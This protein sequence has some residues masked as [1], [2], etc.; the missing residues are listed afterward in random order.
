MRIALACPYAWDAPGG[1]QVHVRELGERLRRRGH[2]VLGLAPSRRPPAESWMRAVGRPIDV[3]YNR[4]VAPICFSLASAR[5]VRG[6]LRSF[7]PD[8][9]HAHEPLTPSV[10]MFAL[11]AGVAPVVATF[12]SGAERSLLFDVAAPVLRR[13][14]ERIAV[15]VAVSRAAA[16]FAARRVGDG[17]RVVPNGIDLER[18][19]N[20]HPAPL[21]PGRRVL[22]VGRL[23]ERKGFPTAVEAFSLL[24]ARAPDVRLVAVGDGPDA[25]AVEDVP[26]AI[27]QRIVLVGRVP[28]EAL[29]A[30]LAAA[31]LLVAPSVGGESFGVVLLE[32]M[33]AGLPVVASAIPGYDEVVEHGVDGLLVPPRRPQALAAAIERVLSDRRLAEDLGRAGRRRASRYG[34]DEVAERLEAIYAEAAGGPR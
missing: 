28:N 1:V 14:A 15:R 21:P 7:A 27:R 6:E 31:D 11:R 17:I 12:H 8:V 29:H 9:V 10:S 33:A 24:A 19:A 13:L 16:G 30:Y 18:F 26:H 4:S 22:F 20:A 3:P 32:A 23:D 25:R 34:W 5:R 2:D